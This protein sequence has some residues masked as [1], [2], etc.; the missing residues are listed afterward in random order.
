MDS[1]GALFQICG[2]LKVMLC[3]LEFES[4]MES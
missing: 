3:A 4:D 1:D 2:K